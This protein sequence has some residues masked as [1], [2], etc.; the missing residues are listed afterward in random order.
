LGELGIIPEYREEDRRC[1]LVEKT[2]WIRSRKGGILRLMVSEGEMV[3]AKQ[4]VGQVS[5]PFGDAKI[6][7]KSPFRGM[8]IGMT[9]SPLVH[10]GDAVVHVGRLSTE[11]T[12]KSNVSDD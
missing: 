7:L 1:V 9:L 5:D 4:T 11:I 3:E 12:G 10:A 2:S 8:I 6:L